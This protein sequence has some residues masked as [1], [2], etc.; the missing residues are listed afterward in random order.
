MPSG[1]VGRLWMK[2]DTMFFCGGG[3]VLNRDIFNTIHEEIDADK[4]IDAVDRMNINEIQYLQQS[5][6]VQ[7][8]WQAEV[9]L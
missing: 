9:L 3:F 6:G 7:I 1:M 4:D 2:I 8:W 5:A